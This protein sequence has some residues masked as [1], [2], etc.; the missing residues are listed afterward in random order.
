MLQLH[1]EKGAGDMRRPQKALGFRSDEEVEWDTPER[2][3]RTFL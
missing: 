1:H 3:G 2:G